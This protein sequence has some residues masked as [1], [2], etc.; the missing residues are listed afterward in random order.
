MVVMCQADTVI[1]R[2]DGCLEQTQ[3][4]PIIRLVNHYLDINPDTFGLEDWLWV[5]MR[6]SRKVLHM[7]PSCGTAYEHAEEIG[8]N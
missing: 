2:C 6:K 8:F 3:A 5:V 4:L 1:V 7:C